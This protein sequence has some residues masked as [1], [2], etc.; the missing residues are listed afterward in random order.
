MTLIKVRSSLT[1]SRPNIQ[2]RNLEGK[3]SDSREKSIVSLI[4]A[5][6]RVRGLSSRVPLVRKPRENEITGSQPERG[7]AEK[8]RK[9]AA[10]SP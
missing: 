5:R 3:K 4:L 8:K 2:R 1:G 10:V 6:F 9:R 7:F